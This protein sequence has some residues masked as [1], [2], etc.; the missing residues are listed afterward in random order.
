MEFILREAERLIQKHKTRNPLRLPIVLILMFSTGPS[1][2]L[3]G[4]TY[5]QGGAGISAL[6]TIWTVLPDD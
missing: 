1:A 3:K 6:T 2:S 5:T 4:F